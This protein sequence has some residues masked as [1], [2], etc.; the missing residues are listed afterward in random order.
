MKRRAWIGYGLAA[1]LGASVLAFA[2]G[3]GGMWQWLDHTLYRQLRGGEEPPP[4]P[5]IQLID[6]QQPAPVGNDN[7][8]RTGSFRHRVGEVLQALAAGT[9]VPS[10]VVLD[11]WFAA[12]A[13]GGE[14]ILAGIAALR[15]R[16]ARVVGAVNLIERHGQ[17]SQ[18]PLARHDARIYRHALD[19]YGH[20]ELHY[21]YGVLSYERDVPIRAAGDSTGLVTEAL[22]A[23]PLVAVLDPTRVDALPAA[24]VV[25]VGDD[26][27]FDARV[28]RIAT[29]GLPL[30]AAE[31]RQ[32]AAVAAATH[33]IV[34]S[35]AADSDNVL[36]RPGPLLI[37]WAMSDLLAG[38]TSEH[39]APLN[40]PGVALLLALAA[41]LGAGA[42]AVGAFHV[43]RA[44]VASPNW[45]R[46]ALACLLLGC[47]AGVAL[48]LTAQA[49]ALSSAQFVP[50][51]W[52]ASCAL[53]AA[54]LATRANRR[55]IDDARVRIEQQQADVE[56]AIRYD[57]FVSYAHDPPENSEWV[58]EHVVRPLAQMSAPDGRRLRIFFDERSIEV[59]RAWKREIE[60]ALLGSRCVVP[61][62]SERYFD[63]P[64]CREEIE[65]ADQLRIEGRL[66]LLPVARIASGIPERFLRKVQYLDA[67]GGRDVTERLLARVGLI[68]AG[69]S[70][71]PG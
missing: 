65:L 22:P 43:L 61:I 59:G 49:I 1:A 69:A 58:R 32:L 20:T 21:H 47:L 6:L 55:W 34:G 2:G 71:A 42:A 17:R 50:L 15:A 35:F 11:V 45:Y 28:T 60:L 30:E 62:Y 7:A 24:L 18:D 16:G 44:R 5:G 41:A 52:P 63:R 19:G 39:R 36:S 13:S 8:E 68:L 64:Y 40:R 33:V 26:R 53:L 31:R 56:R 54:L 27:A 23:L 3:I 9:R 29:T 25:P 48:L 12:D 46:L 66:E 57:V 4:A 38:R 67:T 51:A 70:Q 37:A 10:V 14:A